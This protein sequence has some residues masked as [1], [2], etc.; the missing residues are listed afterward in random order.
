MNNSIEACNEENQRKNR[1]IVY[2]GAKYKFGE[3]NYSLEIW[4]EI[5]FLD[6]FYESILKA[7]AE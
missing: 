4:N 6:F 5:E 7:K 1:G 2:K 3:L